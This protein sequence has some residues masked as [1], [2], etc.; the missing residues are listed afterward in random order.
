MAKTADINFSVGVTTSTSGSG[1]GAKLWIDNVI[2]Y[3]IGDII[4]DDEAA[5]AI[6]ALVEALDEAVYNATD[7]SALADAKAT[8]SGNKTLDNYNALNDALVDAQASVAT[9]AKLDAAITNAEGWTATTV[10]QNIRTKYTSGTYSNETTAAD[11]YEEYQAAE[12]VALKAA[13]ATDYTSVILNPSFETG[14]MTGWSAE[15]RYDT[16]VKLN[17][18]TTYTTSGVD[19]S[20]LFNSWGGAAENNVY[21]TI[22]GLPEG[23]YTLSALLAGFTGE[24]LVLAANSETTSVTVKGDKTT[25]NKVNVVF[26]LD[27]DGDV[28][29]KASNTKSQTTSDA[30]FIKADNFTLS[31]GDITTGDYTALNA[32]IEA[33]ETHK[34]GFDAGEYAPYENKEASAA[35]AAAKAVDQ[36]VAMAQ[37]DLDAIVSALTSATWKANNAEVDAIYDGQFANTEA[38]ATSGDIML[39]G[40]T[41]VA[42]IRVLTKDVNT[43]LGLAY[44]DGRA[45]LFSW[46]TTTLTYGEQTGY[47]LP[48]EKNELYE[49]TLKVSAW[50]DGAYP[51][52]V[53]VA[54]D[55]EG[56]SVNPVAL[57]VMPI[58]T[59]EGN[60]FVSLKFYLEPTADNSILTIYGNQHFTIADLSMKKVS[61]TTNDLKGIV[62]GVLDKNGAVLSDVTKFVNLYLK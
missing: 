56:K 28:V 60:P 42:G 49:V 47:T 45:A 58:N 12:I 25:G 53:T 39:P 61:G 26:T 8:F 40:W 50:R 35:L 51:S 7:K 57:G 43:D 14:D 21:Q 20:Y 48:L 3:R 13:S 44:T 30:S 46:G 59:A 31:A 33:A 4:M 5:N 24:T 11:I 38:N 36:S 22:K 62:N 41:N 54:L 19:G 27:Q 29:I 2:V 15:G 52:V 10:V 34:F 18:N 55:G 16:G 23:T 37:A 1:N 32:A 17:S 9:Y 6:I